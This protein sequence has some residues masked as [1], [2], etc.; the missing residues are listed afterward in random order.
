MVVTRRITLSVDGK[1][2]AALVTRVTALLRM[3]VTP[4]IRTMPGGQGI[5]PHEG[6]IA[7]EDVAL[8]VVRDILSELGMQ[9]V[10]P[11]HRLVC[12]EQCSP[13]SGGHCPSPENQPAG[14]CP[15]HH[16]LARLLNVARM[17]RT[18]PQEER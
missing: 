14:R 1:H 11:H 5:D 9:G 13:F 12:I 10:S 3:S 15:A 2:E 16:E 7:L 8:S 17:T 18:T 4:Q 6:P